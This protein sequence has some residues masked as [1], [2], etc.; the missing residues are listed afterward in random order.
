MVIPIC[1]F[2]GVVQNFVS[3]EVSVTKNAPDLVS[4]RVFG[5]RSKV[6][7]IGGWGVRGVIFGKR[8]ILTITF[9]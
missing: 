1:L 5:L 8:T 9:T 6:K 2:C 7:G 4:R 3:W